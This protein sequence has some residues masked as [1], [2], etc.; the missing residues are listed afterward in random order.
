MGHDP[1]LVFEGFS[2]SSFSTSS[3]HGNT[4]STQQRS[5]TG[6][7]NFY[8]QTTMSTRKTD[9]TTYLKSN[10][11]VKCPIY[12][13]N[14]SHSLTDCVKFRGKTLSNGLPLQ[15]WVLCEVL[16]FKASYSTELL[17]KCEMWIYRS[18]N[19]PSPWTWVLTWLWGGSSLER[20]IKGRVSSYVPIVLKYVALT[21][22]VEPENHVQKF[23][24]YVCILL[25]NI[26]ERARCYAW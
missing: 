12:G 13:S 22:H 3:G 25:V 21:I 10:V 4:R 6:Q 5:N 14:S 16:W 23:Y 24:Q 8:R 17:R 19:N 20:V 1:S 15:E 9:V 2:T 18:C 11:V 7:R 26:F